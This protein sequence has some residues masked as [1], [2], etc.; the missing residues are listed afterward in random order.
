MNDF[1]DPVKAIATVRDVAQMVGLSPARFYQLMHAGIFPLPL[2]DIRT[3]RPHFDV[4]QQRVCLEVRR[5][6]CGINGKAICFYARRFGAQPPAPRLRAARPS[7][8][9]R[10][11]AEHAGLVDA[12]RGLGLAGVT[13]QQ[14]AA[15]VKQLYPKGTSE[16]PE[17]E[18]IRAVF[19]HLKRQDRGDSVR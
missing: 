18:V 10:Q 9:P 14:V 19:L 4:E 12:I 3:R 16:T 2:Y 17:P 1:D 11:K 6:N 7:S 13:A 8:A 5:K 15:V